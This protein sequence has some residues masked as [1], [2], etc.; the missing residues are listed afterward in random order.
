MVSALEDLDHLM[1]PSIAMYGIFKKLLVE[2]D[3]DRASLVVAL[4]KQ[5]RVVELDSDLSIHSSRGGKGFKPAIRDSIIDTTALKFL[6]R[7]WTQ[8]TQDKNLSELPGA[9]YFRKE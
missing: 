9:Q 4:M 6:C 1:V 7:P 3:E 8:G 2:T 5:G